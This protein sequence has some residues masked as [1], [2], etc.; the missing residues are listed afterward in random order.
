MLFVELRALVVRFAFYLK[1][2]LFDFPKRVYSIDA[3]RRYAETMR[4]WGPCTKI[5]LHFPW[6]LIL[7]AIFCRD[8]S[9]ASICNSR[10]GNLSIRF[11]SEAIRFCFALI[12]K[13]MQ[14]FSSLLLDTQYGS[15][16]SN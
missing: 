14:H 4:P 11:R 5:A 9:I 13:R 2:D 10:L 8:S 3:I 16:E 15:N 6:A 1:A 7:F 12:M